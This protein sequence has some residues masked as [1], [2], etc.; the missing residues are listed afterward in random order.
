MKRITEFYVK[1]ECDNAD[2]FYV[3]LICDSPLDGGVEGTGEEDWTI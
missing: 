3:D 2:A 1:P